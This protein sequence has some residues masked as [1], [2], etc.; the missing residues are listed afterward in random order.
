MEEREV[1]PSSFIIIIICYCASSLFV[2]RRMIFQQAAKRPLSAP[3][4][5]NHMSS[6]L[7]IMAPQLMNDDGDEN[8]NDDSV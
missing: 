1:S 4:Q 5:E 6:P 8:E 2:Q 3:G 7:W